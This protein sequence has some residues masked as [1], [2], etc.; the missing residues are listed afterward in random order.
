MY[1]FMYE[2]IWSRHIQ[3]C[4]YIYIYVYLLL[5][6]TLNDLTRVRDVIHLLRHGGRHHNHAILIIKSTNSP[7]DI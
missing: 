4:I 2:Y 1:I 3:A 7:T 5:D 6:D